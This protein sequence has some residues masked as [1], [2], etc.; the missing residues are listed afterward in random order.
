MDVVL[1]GLIWHVSS[2]LHFMKNLLVE[3]LPVHSDTLILDWGA[4]LERTSA[5]AACLT[6][7][8]LAGV[9]D[10]WPTL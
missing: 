2:P 3:T 10:L 5:V 6:V 1:S 8:T 9:Y 7:L 4:V